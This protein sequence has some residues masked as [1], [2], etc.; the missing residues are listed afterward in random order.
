ML[1]DGVADHGHC[2]TREP[3]PAVRV[4]PLHR[5]AERQLTFLDQVLAGHAGR[6]A[7]TVDDVPDQADVGLEERV[8]LGHPSC[9]E[10]PDVLTRPMRSASSP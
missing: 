3:R 8:P 1:R 4:E 5:A 2:I 10:T 9:G 7:V 6:P